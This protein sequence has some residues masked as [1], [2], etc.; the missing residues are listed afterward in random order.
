MKIK[1]KNIIA[2][3]AT[4]LSFL[5]ALAC[6]EVSVDPSA[7]INGIDGTNSNKVK[8]T[9]TF[10]HNV[11]I[12]TQ[13][14]L[15]IAGINGTINLESVSGTSQVTISGEK[16]VSAHTYQDASSHLEYLNVEINELTNEL[17]VRTTQP[18]NSN[19]RTYTVNYTIK[20]PENLN[21]S[22]KEI[23]GKIEG[24]VVIPLQGILDVALT[25]GIVEIDIP[26]T[27]SAEFSASTLNGSISTRNLV[28]HNKI[29]T[30]RSVKGTLGDGEGT[31]SFR[32]TNGIIEVAGF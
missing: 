14:T 7:N 31:A 2:V 32:T 17:L 26:Q 24:K 25:S 12:T 15:K 4:M 18:Q 21:L 6:T 10:F 20:I 30:L 5:F 27:T 3:I 8:A 23:N 1:G 9:K 19:G 13:N 11:D 16:I 28:L 22:V 29:E